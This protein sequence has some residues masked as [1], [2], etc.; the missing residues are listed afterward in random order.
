MLHDF[1]E[2]T[3]LREK[4]A[5]VGASVL[6]GGRIGESLAV[7]LEPLPIDAGP[8]E[9]LQEFEAHVADVR[10]GAEHRVLG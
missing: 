8:L 7:R 9:R 2:S 5:E 10:L 1:D 4:F 3:T 6:M